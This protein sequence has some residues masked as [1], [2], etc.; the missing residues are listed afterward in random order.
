MLAP[1]GAIPPDLGQH[2]LKLFTRLQ[3]MAEVEVGG[4]AVGANHQPTSLSG[5]PTVTIFQVS[6]I[7]KLFWPLVTTNCGGIH[8]ANS[9][10]V[11][12]QVLWP[13]STT[14][15]GGLRPQT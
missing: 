1:Q 9:L 6:V 13:L 15:C 8:A 7:F 4:C 11:T 12:S 2:S 14:I 3:T 5:I 10:P